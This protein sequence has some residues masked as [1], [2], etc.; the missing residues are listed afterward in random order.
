MRW[1]TNG[2]RGNIV[3]RIDDQTRAAVADLLVQ[4]EVANDA[5]IASLADASAELVFYQSQIVSG[6]IHDVAWKVASL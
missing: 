4:S 2:Y 5:K 3:H 6:I 1:R